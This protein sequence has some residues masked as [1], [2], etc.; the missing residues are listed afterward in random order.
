MAEQGVA[1]ATQPVETA[2]PDLRRGG[3]PYVQGAGEDAYVWVESL[4][5]SPSTFRHRPTGNVFKWEGSGY[6]GCII[7]VPV[8]VARDPFFR[9]NINRERL[10]FVDENYA[11][12]RND[13]MPFRDDV[14]PSTGRPFDP[15]VSQI[16]DA[17]APGA[18][19][20]LG[21]RYKKGLNLPELG[22]ERGEID[23]SDIW[24]PDAGKALP[25]ATSPQ[26][27]RQV[28]RAGE[29]ID[30]VNGVASSPTDVGGPKRPED[31]LTERA[32]EGDPGWGQ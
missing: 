27:P 32:H 2:A 16:M 28:R 11:L 22:R 30:P 18:M 24:G 10:R 26:Q 19:E 13:D 20:N 14:D 31:V 8:R 3:I 21:G 6:L 12:D 15:A 29:Q 9:R 1:T 23:P 4:M 25:A 7:E 17:L 5:T